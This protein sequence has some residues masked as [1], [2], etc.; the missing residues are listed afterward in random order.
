[1]IIIQQTFNNQENFSDLAQYQIERLN[2]IREEAQLLS[3]KY[4]ELSKVNSNINSKSICIISN[5]KNNSKNYTNDTN[6]INDNISHLSN[7]FINKD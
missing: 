7:N 4:S 3:E 6:D 5:T 2:Q 1:M